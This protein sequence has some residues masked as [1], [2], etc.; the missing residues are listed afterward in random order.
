MRLLT[1]NPTKSECSD[2]GMAM[3]LILL[4]IGF[5]TDNSIYFKLAIP[6]LLLNMIYSKIFYF[7]AIVWLSGSQLI[8]TAVSK[9][10]LSLIYITVVLPVALVRQIMGRDTLL[11][12]AWRKNKSSIMIKRNHIY[13][14]ED[15]KN[16]Y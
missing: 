15:I 11:L 5:F 10:L 7:V 4:L 13:T 14:P 6:V 16:P 2:T 1:T 3:I 8:G 12:K 9:V